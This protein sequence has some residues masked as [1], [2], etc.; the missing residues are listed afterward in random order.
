M[1]N[2][3]ATSAAMGKAYTM[4]C[5]NWKTYAYARFPRPTPRPR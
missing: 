4:N 2:T 1:V 5:G 3:V